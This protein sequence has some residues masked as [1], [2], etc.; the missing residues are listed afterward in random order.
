MSA[1]RTQE[2]RARAIAARKAPAKGIRSQRGS[3]TKSLLHPRWRGDGPRSDLLR[4]ARRPHRHDAASSTTSRSP[5]V[6]VARGVALD[7]RVDRRALDR[8]GVARRSH[9][10]DQSHWRSPV[11]SGVG[12]RQEMSA[13]RTQEVRARAI[14]ARKAPA[15]GI[16][17]Q[18]GSSTK[19]LLHPR[20]RGDGP[21]SD[22][23]RPARSLIVTTPPHQR[24]RGA[25]LRAR[26]ARLSARAARLRARAGPEV[27]SRQTP[28]GGSEAQARD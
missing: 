16:R 20:W 2:V 28:R 21:R 15:K 3:S 12:P 4:P 25:R 11:Q 24:R 9:S 13:Q 17:S 8:V 27:R 5:V 19:S 10:G 23:L 1:Q 6:A 7:Q 22:L 18:R 26:A 14:A